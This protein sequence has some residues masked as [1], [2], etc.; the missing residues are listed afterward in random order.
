VPIV[1][2]SKFEILS[3]ATRAAQRP[4]KAR[5]PGTRPGMTL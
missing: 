4:S 2:G 5:M 1:T 3:L